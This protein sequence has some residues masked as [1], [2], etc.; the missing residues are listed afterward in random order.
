MLL[1]DA[2]R[3]RIQAIFQRFLE[4]RVRNVE[5]LTLDQLKFN[6]IALRT[7]APMLEL[8]DPTALL[9][10]RLAQNLERSSVT[11]MGSALQQV[12]REIAGQGTGVAGADIMLER[13]GRRYYIQV[14]SG[15]DTANKDIAQ[16]IATLLNSARA[17]DPEAIC[18][19][20]VCY[21]RAEQ[22]SPIARGELTNRGVGLRVGRE[23]WEF[24]S[25]NPDCMADVLELAG[26]AASSADE[27]PFAE[28][29]ER[30]LDALAADFMIRYGRT[31]DD[32]TWARFLADNS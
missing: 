26:A 31:L 21:G 7:S 12:A 6:V 25:G 11:A 3:A 19:L 8:D 29:V 10:Y 18:L 14:K 15:P 28:R 20:G 13:D 30:R 5:R 1:T 24:I 22:I 2:Q 27:A 17:R 9:R 32:D 23:F 4:G 16:N